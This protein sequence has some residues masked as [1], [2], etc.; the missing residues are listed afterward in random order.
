MIDPL[1]FTEESWGYSGDKFL[2][3]EDNSPINIAQC[4]YIRISLSKDIDS[5]LEKRMCIFLQIRRTSSLLSPL[6]RVENQELTGASLY[7]NLLHREN[8][9]L[10]NLTTIDE[11]N[12]LNRLHK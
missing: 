2:S 4:H 11:I 5:S 10:L 6:L 9:V 3:F 12:T 8:N 1:S 7:Q